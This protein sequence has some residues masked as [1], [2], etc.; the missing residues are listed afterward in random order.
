MRPFC[1]GVPSEGSLSILL[2]D[3]DSVHKA[4]ILGLLTDHGYGV[5][6]ASRGNEALGI[7][8]KHPGSI[9][10]LM[11]DLLMPGMN[12]RELARQACRILPGLKAV[13]LA[14]WVHDSSLQS[15][16]ARR[17]TFFLPK[18]FAIEAF[19]ALLFCMPMHPPHRG[20]TP[21]PSARAA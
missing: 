14:A 12:G 4:F 8:R 17:G 16:L 2:V 9:D 7:L 10:L 6:T 1:H 5:R 11:T 3:D 13:F 19:Q 20:H 21:L 18:P 15:S